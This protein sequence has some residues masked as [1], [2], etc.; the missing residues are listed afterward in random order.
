M[1]DRLV[2][3]TILAEADRVMG[4]D[5]DLPQLHQCRH[6]DGVACV[7]GEHQEGGGVGKQ[8][9][10]QRQAVGDRRHGELTHA[11]VDVV[12]AL[13]TSDRLRARPPGQVRS[14]QVRRATD[15]LRQARRQ[16][17]D[18]PLRGLARRD[19]AGSGGVGQATG[20]GIL[21]AGRQLAA[22]A[23]A[24]LGSQFGKGFR[25]GG[26]APLPV[27]LEEA[28]AGT[29]IPLCV[30]LDG[31]LERRVRP[32]DVGARRSDF[33][34][35]ERCAVCIVA[36]RLVGRTKA[37]PRPAADQRRPLAL[38]A[39]SQQRLVDRLR[40]VAVDVGDHP[41]AVGREALP[42]I[43]GEPAGDVAID[44][45]AVVVVDGDQLAE[46]EGAG[47]RARLVR[48]ALH[49]AAVADED[50]GRVV[51]DFVPGPVELGGEDPFGDRH[52]DGVGQP[53]PE[54]PGRRL[55]AGCVPDLGMTR[56]PRAE[57]AELLQ[58]VEREVIAAEMQQRIEQHRAVP[59]REDEA[60]T[61]RPARIG[62]VVAQ[63]ATPEHF[64][65]FGHPHRHPGVTGVGLLHRVHGEGADDTGQGGKWCGHDA[66]RV[67]DRRLNRIGGLSAKSGTL[68]T[69]VA[70]AHRP[71]NR[72]PLAAGGVARQAGLAAAH[73]SAK[74]GGSIGKRSLTIIRKNFNFK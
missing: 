43:V 34:G 6:A 19:V 64:R 9:P 59:V 23:A 28:A 10:V 50:V 33:G 48:D 13:L 22:H 67:R 20:D 56:C 45:N 41:P 62:R 44:R 57:L 65:D 5:H 72:A 54:R 21:P 31:N 68:A 73:M 4:I 27:A 35:S 14:G 7:V 29:A 38:A 58:V 32:A 60:V 74:H 1:L 3:R 36:A 71:G 69:F 18:G 39:R 26:E 40:V 12:A 61:I 51:D 11:V 37:D 16:G 66:S 25:V 47:E 8:P 55:D 53:L 42:A 49:Q 63:V 15:Q 17:S 46:P 70:A 30:N 2:R 52:A 24:E